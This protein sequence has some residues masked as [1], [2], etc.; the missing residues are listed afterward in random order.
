MDHRCR[1]QFLNILVRYM[2][3]LNKVVNLKDI[4][5]LWL[6]CVYPLHVRILCYPLH[7]LSLMFSL[8]RWIFYS[9]EMMLGA[10]VLTYFSVLHASMTSHV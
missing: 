2:S 6:A 4:T 9:V 7:V 10:F 8:H 1:L 5:H 3:L